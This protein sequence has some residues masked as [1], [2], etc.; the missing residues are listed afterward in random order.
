MPEPISNSIQDYLKIIY[1]LTRN[2]KS[3]STNALAAR[4]GIAPASV[5]GMMQ[6]LSS[7]TPALV[8]YRKHQGVTLTAAGERAALEVI[9]HH[10]LIEAWLVRAL[11]YSWDEVHEEAEK[12]EHVISENFELRIA[13]A[14]GDPERDPH[15]EPIPSAELVM[16]ADNSIPLSSMQPEQEAALRRVDAQETEFLR[17]LEELG[18]IPGTHLKLLSV[19]PYDQV[20]R[21]HIKGQKQTVAIGP[22]ITKRVFIEIL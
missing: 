22:A 1:E 4:L 7:I 16:P 20:M 19:S 3:A 15:G 6:K 12:L 18:L 9:R 8:S 14:L 17:Y 13:A 2:E 11:G 10:R 5:T 21:I